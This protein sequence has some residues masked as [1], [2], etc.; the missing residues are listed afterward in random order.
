MEMPVLGIDI[1]KKKFD[2]ALL[3]NGKVKHKACANTPEGFIELQEW[4]GRQG[5]DRVH[6]CMEATN[7]YGDALAATLFE[8]GHVVSV[9]NPARIKGFAQSELIRTKNDKVDAAL[10]A[11]FGAALRPEPW[12]PPP[13][14]VRELQALVRR[15]DA[16]NDMH[17]QESNR[18]ETTAASG[19]VASVQSV[20]ACLDH[21]IATVERL[22]QDHF[23][24]HPGLKAQRDLL[25]SIPGIGDKTAAVLLAEIRGVE[26]FDSARQ[27][28]AYSGLAPR[29]WTSGSSVRG[30]SRLSKTGNSHLRRALYMP[31]IVAKQHNPLIRAFCQRLLDRGKAPKAV[32]GV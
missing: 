21:E 11:R 9:V 30:K 17:M 15:L 31:A 32:I 18:L 7:T 5:G 28:A 3:L 26:A 14:E 4:L 19:V 8:A 2:A 12:T 10:I 25:T 29:E 22:I 27:L 23:D 13:A 6:A 16:L 20:L 1:A 24:Q